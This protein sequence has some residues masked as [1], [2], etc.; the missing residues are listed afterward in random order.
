MPFGF[1]KGIVSVVRSTETPAY[2]AES[3]RWW[4]IETLLLRLQPPR[5]VASQVLEN[6]PSI[7][8]F[9]SKK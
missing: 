7:V 4:S 6:P 8:P 2:A 3:Q 5:N 1:T 9:A